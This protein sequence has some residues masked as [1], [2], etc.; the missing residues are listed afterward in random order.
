MSQSRRITA[1]VLAALLASAGLTALG[2]Q[3]RRR[4]SPPANGGVSAGESRLTGV[5]RLNVEASDDPRA[6]AER[7]LSAYAFDAEQTVVEE[8]V[9]RLSSPDQLSIER[10]G[11]VVS[12]AS[13]R[14]PRIS[15]EADGR[16]RTE[17]SRD[18]QVVRTRAVLHGDDL[19]VSSSGSRDNDFS[20]TFSPLDGGR[21]LR[22]TRRIFSE[23]LGQ[24]VVVQSIY[25]KTS[26][27]ARWSVYGEPESARTATARNDRRPMPPGGAGNRPQPSPPPAERRFPPG[28][29]AAP[30]VTPE[31]GNDAYAL[32]V[33]PGT[34]IVAAL[35]NHLNTAWLREDDGFTMT[36]RA[37][38]Q[39]EGAIIEGYVS[40][41]ERAGP[42]SGRSGMT[43]EFTRIRLRDGREAPF[44]GSIENVLPAG[45]EAV[46]VDRE[47]ATTVEENRSRTNRTAQRAAIGAAVGAIIGAIAGGGK[48]A[49][50]GAAIGAGAGA[51]SVYIQGRG[52]LELR[53]GTELRIRS[54]R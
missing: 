39:F 35:D 18:G 7:A 15:F 51:S 10:R 53:R 38:S 2:Q 26:S 42:F 47:E 6:T 13:T 40:R 22:V 14:A 33:P 37:P 34:E 30:P 21:R 1:L 45:G 46:R 52:N 25:D 16:E 41:V 44:S 19:M 23:E 43:L 36:V 29:D 5:Y 12:I 9:N 31:D 50:I 24:P 48:G 28:P 54:G 32:V 20:V 49:A 3:P 8:L 27:V 4:P 11:N 17:P